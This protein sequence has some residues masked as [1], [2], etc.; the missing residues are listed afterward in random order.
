M[1]EP[2][3]DLGL[4][5][6]A[7]NQAKTTP[8]LSQVVKG[9]FKRKF[10]SVISAYL[11]PQNGTNQRGKTTSR[12]TRRKDLIVTAYFR[13]IKK[14]PYFLVEEWCTK[15]L[16]KSSE[17]GHYIRAFVEASASF[18][19]VVSGDSI[20]ETDRVDV[21]QTIKDFIEFVVIYFP[22]EKWLDL[23]S[24]LQNTVQSSEISDDWRDALWTFLAQQPR[25]LE[26]RQLTTKHN[27]RQWICKSKT[28]R[29]MFEVCLAVLAEPDFA[30]SKAGEELRELTQWFLAP[31]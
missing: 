16:Y 4:A 8:E 15:N 14:L 18:H 25:I 30:S 1:M 13:A 21:V 20:I 12:A 22:Q 6:D 17:M 26:N 3:W 7:S 19:C 11:E 23:I 24:T 27:I 10:H 31:N 5:E 2:D 9:Y 28:L 29:Q